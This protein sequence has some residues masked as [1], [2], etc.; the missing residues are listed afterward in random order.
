MYA[1]K[2]IITITT[3]ANGD[4]VES[5]KAMNGRILS[6]DYL[7]VGTPFANGVDFVIRNKST[8]QVILAAG[9][10]ND[11]ITFV[12][13]QPVNQVADA[14]EITNAWGPLILADEQVEITIENGGA[15]RTGQFTV[16]VG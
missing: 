9:N 6:I 12:P 4:A 7:K 10:V 16:K 14:A 15:T 2:D 11:D 5:I 3:D 1:D 8:D 13:G